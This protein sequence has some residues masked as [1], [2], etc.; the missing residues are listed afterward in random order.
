MTGFCVMYPAGEEFYGGSLLRPR[1]ATWVVFYWPLWK[2]S[3]FS[4]KILDGKTYVKIRNVALASNWN[5]MFILN[6]LNFKY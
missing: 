3:S 1:D 4:I 6:K 2:W 5:E